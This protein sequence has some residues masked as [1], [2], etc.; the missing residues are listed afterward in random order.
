MMETRMINLLAGSNDSSMSIVFAYT[1]ICN[2]FP[3][4][5]QRSMESDFMEALSFSILGCHKAEKV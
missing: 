3:Y 1:S 5:F 2:F 4:N